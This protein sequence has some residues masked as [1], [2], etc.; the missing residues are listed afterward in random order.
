MKKVYCIDVNCE[1][2]LAQELVNL[3]NEKVC[4]VFAKRKDAIKHLVGS[5]HYLKERYHEELY[6][7]TLHNNT[8]LQVSQWETITIDCYK[9]VVEDDFDLETDSIFETDNYHIIDSRYLCGRY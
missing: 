8:F 4:R 3:M 7:V 6:G 2:S 9:A 5:Y 1:T